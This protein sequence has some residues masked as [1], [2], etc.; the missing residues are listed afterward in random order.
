MDRVRGR[1]ACFDE[2]EAKSVEFIG[3]DEH[4][5][6]SSAVSM[7]GVMADASV[8][9]SLGGRVKVVYADTV[10]ERSWA[11]RGGERSDVAIG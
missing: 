2:F 9:E 10:C 1:S 5:V 7:D 11:V 4:T 8:R 3:V 6:G